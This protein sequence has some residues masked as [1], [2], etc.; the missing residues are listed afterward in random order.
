MNLSQGTPKNEQ[1]CN[2]TGE[3]T[4]YEFRLTKG[5]RGHQEQ[6]QRKLNCERASLEVTQW[7]DIGACQYKCFQTSASDTSKSPLDVLC[8]C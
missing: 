6:G 2:Y 7:G 8:T 1:N 4:D 5:H 3:I